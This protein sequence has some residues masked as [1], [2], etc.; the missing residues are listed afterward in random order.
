VERGGF[1]PPKA[2][3]ADLQSA[4]F[5]R[6]GTSPQKKN[7]FV[8]LRRPNFSTWSWRWE[9]NPQP[10]DYKS[11][12][13]PLSYASR[14]LLSAA[15]VRRQI[16]DLYMLVNIIGSVKIFLEIALSLLSRIFPPNVPKP[17][18][19]GKLLVFCRQQHYF[20]KSS[21]LRS[22]PRPYFTVLKVRLQEVIMP[23]YE[24]LCQD[25]GFQFEK[26]V[27]G[28]GEAIQCPV[29]HKTNVVKMMSA[30]TLKAGCKVPST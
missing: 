11:A 16:L 22:L 25:C 5:G 27:L 26:L 9:S 24:F 19:R 30:C 15:S 1:E 20:K 18:L 13:L 23:I 28:P 2:S 21:G 3:P 6:S 14:S 12:A 17:T 10:A 29:C 7:F 8:P 4:P